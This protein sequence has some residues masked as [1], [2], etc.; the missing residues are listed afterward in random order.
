MNFLTNFK[1]HTNRTM[2]TLLALLLLLPSLSWGSIKLACQGNAMFSIQY[3]EN[4]SQRITN[5]K[6]REEPTVT[7]SENENMIFVSGVVDDI[8]TYR[9]ETG[10][11]YEDEFYG[12]AMFEDE[13][14]GKIWI[15][16]ISGVMIRV[17]FLPNMKNKKTEVEL[18]YDCE[19]IRRKF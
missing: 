7:I 8:I 4:D 19:P 9:I 10:R 17:N 13:I 3:P 5:T 2:K 1:T 6:Y 15:D 11:N 12:E 16:R 14:R 18:F